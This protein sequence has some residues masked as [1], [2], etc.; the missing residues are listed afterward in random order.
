LNSS[1]VIAGY[2]PDDM[3]GRHNQSSQ[4]LKA[5]PFYDTYFTTKSY[6]VD[7]LKNL[8]C[9]NVKFIENAYDPYSTSD[10][11]DEYKETFINNL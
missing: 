8:G 7:E 2:S 3:A 9:P 11:K 5:L 1:T 6:N 4:F 10:L